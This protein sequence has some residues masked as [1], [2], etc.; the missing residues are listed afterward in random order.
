MA[1]ISTEALATI[2][3]RRPWTV[4]GIWAALL[5][6]SVGITAALLA[7]A[8]TTDIEFTSNPESKKGATLLED[9]LR[10]PEKDNEIV[11]VQ[12]ADMTVDDPAFQATVEDIYSRVAALGRR[13]SP[14]A[15]PSTRRTTSPCL[16]RQ[17]HDD[18]PVRH[19]RRSR[20]GRRQHLRG[21]RHR[22]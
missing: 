11:I 2:S 21:D 4:I 18:H 16:R 13:S 6:A 5:F 10:G 15:R 3:A 9:K 1:F 17:A 7:G 22:R 20:N 14:A 12:S 19:G 8:L